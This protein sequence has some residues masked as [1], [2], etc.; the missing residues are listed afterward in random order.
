[1]NLKAKESAVCHQPNP[2]V[3]RTAKWRLGWLVKRTWACAIWQP[4]TFNVGHHEYSSHFQSQET[5]H[6]CT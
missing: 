3:K 2:S 5:Q 6:E 1:M 4:L